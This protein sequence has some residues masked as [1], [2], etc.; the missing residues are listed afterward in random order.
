MDI[1][2]N[3]FRQ[4]TDMPPRVAVDFGYDWPMSGRSQAGWWT[5]AATAAALLAVVSTAAAEPVIQSHRATYR[6]ALVRATQQEGMRG[7][8]GTLAFT[9][10]D[11][12]AGYT[13][14]SR[15]EAD[16]AFSNGLTNQVRQVFAG[17]EAKDRRSASFRMQT[18]END[19]LE[20]SYRGR[21]DLDAEGRGTVVYEGSTRAHY[22]LPA[23]TLLSTGQIQEL[24]RLAAA[25]E[26]FF[27]HVVIDG[28]FI[29]GPYRVTGV[30]GSERGIGEQE[31]KELAAIGR[32]EAGTYWPVT[33]AYFPITGAAETPDYEITLHLLGDGVVA[34]MIQD[35]G[36]Y[37][38]AF[39]P[40]SIR[41][42]SESGC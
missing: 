36:A 25:G 41:K 38:L 21:V 40:T 22:D 8:D 27:S 12:C 32:S 6:I 31:R 28:A 24:L 9:L 26:R 29:E 13:V 5:V 42:I 17:W 23:G 3:K 15:M 33:M 20:D 37:A 18:T 39:E 10:I 14:E 11:R 4:K 16:Y 35:F 2:D 30:I 19:S 1:R 34:R 7:A